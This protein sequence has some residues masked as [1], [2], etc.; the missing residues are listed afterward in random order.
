MVFCF[1]ALM[2]WLPTTCAMAGA[3]VR[4]QMDLSTPAIGF[5][6]KAV[7]GA[8]TSVILVGAVSAPPIDGNCPECLGV[9]D[10]LLADC[11]ENSFSC[12][13]SQDD[14]P[15]HFQEPWEYDG[16]SS[17]AQIRLEG[18]LESEYTSRII[19]SRSGYIRVE[20]FDA[21]GNVDDAEFYFTPGDNTIQFRSNRRGGGT[22]FGANKLRMESIRKKLRFAKVPVLRNRRRVFVFFES[23]FDSFGPGTSKNM[24]V[25]KAEDGPATRFDVD[26]LSPVPRPLHGKRGYQ[27]LP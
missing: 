13:S 22:D 19:A 15:R 17:S 11:P 8:A 18:L 25:G 21:F 3:R 1:Q 5:A 4:C 12:V 10:G 20:F 16:T 7:L 24:D 6:K 26:P 27:E 14:A 2:H 23:P 9:V